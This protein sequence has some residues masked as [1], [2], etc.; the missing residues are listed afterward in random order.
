VS[1]GPEVFGEDYLYFYGTWLTPELDEAQ[2]DLIWRLLGLEP[3]AD[4]LDVACGHG[5]IANRLAGRG[6]QVTGLDAD[7]FFLEKA[8]E[9]GSGAEFV[10]GDMRV[11]PFPDASFDAVLLWFT[12]FGYFDDDGNRAVLN[13]FRRVLRPGGRAAV[14]LQHLPRMLATFQRQSFVR[15]GLDVMLDEHAAFDEEAGILETTRTYIRDGEIREIH[16]RV[17]CLMPD[18]ARDW[19]LEAGFTEV[20]L[21][22]H[23]GEPLTPE[24]RRL[25]AVA[26]APA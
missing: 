7:P 20:E 26:Q 18:E 13:E 9:A 16:Y 25:I 1:V 15:R 22:G 4:V 19:L 14:D 3:G 8:R 10:E 11:L 12:S 23:E 6:A 21:F 2:T 24:S 5:R 17:R